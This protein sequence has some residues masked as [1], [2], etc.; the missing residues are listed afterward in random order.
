MNTVFLHAIRCITLNTITKT[1]HNTCNHKHATHKDQLI[2]AFEKSISGCC[3]WNRLS[4]S[5]FFASSLLTPAAAP[6]SFSRCST[7]IFSTIA[8]VGPSRS[9]SFDDSGVIL[10]TSIAG[11]EVTTCAHQFT[12]LILSRWS[13]ISLPGGWGVVSRV[14]EDSLV[15]MG[16]GR[17]PYSLY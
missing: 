3:S 17:G 10:V 1:N 14:Q 9:L 16:W 13:E 6:A 4:I 8:L 11:A 15:S 12:L 7:I 2:C 5:L